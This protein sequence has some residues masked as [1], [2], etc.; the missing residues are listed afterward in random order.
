MTRTGVL[1]GPSGLCLEGLGYVPSLGIG[2][3]RPKIDSL[4][5]V[6]ARQRYR[7][8]LMRVPHRPRGGRWRSPRA[9][10]V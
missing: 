4:G 7:L 2:L 6:A 1:C 5:F 3:A 8:S 9:V 10:V